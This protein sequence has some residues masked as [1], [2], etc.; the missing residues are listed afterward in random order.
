MAGNRAAA[1]VISGL[2]VAGCASVPR[3]EPPPPGPTPVVEAVVVPQTS[4]APLSGGADL[5]DPARALLVEVDD[6]Y[7]ARDYPRVVTATNELQR[8]AEREGRRDLEVLAISLQLPARVNMSQFEEAEQRKAECDAIE[9]TLNGKLGSVVGE[10]CYAAAAQVSLAQSRP[11][12]ARRSLERA[13]S[14]SSGPVPAYLRQLCTAAE[15]RGASGACT[16]VEAAEN[17]TTTASTSP[18]STLESTSPTNPASG[19]TSTGSAGGASGAGESSS[20]PTSS[21]PR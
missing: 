5:P 16:P 4:I 2:V 17:A 21:R 10:T 18:R 9:E 12:E 20:S 14:F 15:Q 6:A 11:E 1:V 3:V 19:S 7:R 13:A 8:L